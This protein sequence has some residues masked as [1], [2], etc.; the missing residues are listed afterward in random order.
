MIE[1][2]GAEI[3]CQTGGSEEEEKGG[4]ENF[5]VSE[6]SPCVYQGVPECL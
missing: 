4:K 6:E 5:L 1:S 3:I 2:P